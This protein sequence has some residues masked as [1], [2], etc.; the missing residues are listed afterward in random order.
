MHS[1]R[2]RR[3]VLHIGTP[4]TGTTALQVFLAANAESL[5]SHGFNYPA[6]AR[7]GGGH[8]D[9]AFMCSGGYPEWSAPNE[10]SFDTLTRQLKQ[11]IQASPLDL[12]LSSENFYWLCSAE[13]VAELIAALGIDPRN[14]TIVVYLRRQEDMVVSW[15]NQAVKALGYAGT[16]EQHIDQNAE[17][18]DYTT[19]LAKWES[20]FGLSNMHIRTYAASTDICHDFLTFLSL[21]E[22]GFR[23]NEQRFNPSLNRD[24]LEFQRLLNQLPLPTFEKR[25]FHK[26]LMQLSESAA[27][28]S[29]FNTLP[30]LDTTTRNSIYARYADSNRNVAERYLGRNELFEP[31]P[32]D[33]DGGSL[34]PPPYPGLTVDKIVPIFGWLISNLRKET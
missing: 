34:A 23:F 10:H 33:T 29:L 15:Y 7:R 17:L 22:T 12:I 16:L 31:T 2:K 11:E 6:T 21:P 13:I 24:L 5:R 14:T 32:P 25:Q 28:T 26:A 30:L 4:K 19:S 27:G 9:L 1:S 20:A 8:H 3:C 18:W